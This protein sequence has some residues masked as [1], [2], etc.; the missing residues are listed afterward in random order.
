M[1]EVISEPDG[2]FIQ[3]VTYCIIIQYVIHNLVP[4]QNRKL[5]GL[6]KYVEQYIKDFRTTQGKGHATVDLQNYY[7]TGPQIWK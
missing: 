7:G 2:S 4:I 3:G 6:Q 5:I 1:W